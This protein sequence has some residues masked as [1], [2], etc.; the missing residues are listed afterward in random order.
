MRE[1]QPHVLR[2]VHAEIQIRGKL[3]VSPCRIPAVIAD[4]CVVHITPRAKLRP[5][6]AAIAVLL[7]ARDGIA[8]R[9]VAE[10]I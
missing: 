5:A 2:I 7:H 10:I 8:A 6:G 3:H 1:I 4:G 9:I